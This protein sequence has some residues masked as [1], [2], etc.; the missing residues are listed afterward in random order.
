M[1]YPFDVRLV[2]KICRGVEIVLGLLVFALLS[3]VLDFAGGGDNE[4]TAFTFLVFCVCSLQ[5]I[6]LFIY[7]TI[8]G[9]W[10]FVA[11][12]V[13]LLV[14][15]F[16]PESPQRRIGIHAGDVVTMVFFFAGY[17]YHHTCFL[18]VYLQLV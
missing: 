14:E 18:S 2:S 13:L 5:H 15:L 3:R 9:V 10:G 1:G 17:Y 11:G 7:T 12:I 16:V 8:Q 6:A 4:P